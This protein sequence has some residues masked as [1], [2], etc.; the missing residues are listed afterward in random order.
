MSDVT[1]VSPDGDFAG[2][3]GELLQTS[4]RQVWQP[5]LAGSTDP[6][7]E[8]LRAD[9]DV[10]V[11]GPGFDNADDQLA[12][13]AGLEA[14]RPDL[15]VIVV[16]STEGS[17]ALAAMRAGAR[18][19]VDVDA[20]DD[21]L[22]EV[23]ER[24]RTVADRRRLSVSELDE[25]PRRRVITV[26]SPKGGTGKTTVSTNLAVGLARAGVGPVLL[27]DF[28]VQFGDCSGALGLEPEHHLDDAVR[29]TPLDRTVLKMFLAR[30][31]SG[32]HVLAPPASLA[33]ADDID[34][35]QLKVVMGLL[36]EEFPWVVIDTSA[37]I[38]EAA[39]VAME[40]STDLL[41]VGSTDVP[42][43]RALRRQVEALDRIAMNGP[44]RHLV[45]NRADARVGL[46]ADDISATVGLTVRHRIPSSRSI[47][48]STNQGTPAIDANARDSVGK[49]FNQLVA[50]FLPT[51]NT[52][53]DKRRWRKRP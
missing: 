14:R 11:V 43:V 31:E 41:F 32:L 29:A 2:R 40:F 50:S 52:A 38:D 36:V 27:V 35:D 5:D 44:E 49:A 51:T 18:D 22:V 10:V 47:P 34:G 20:D 19:V 30:H 3:I 4:V 26:L 12:V 28:D 37:G 6:V 24:A 46:E 1:I 25:S 16:G 9:P 33:I 42:A 21:E 8:A 53:S 23:V 7:S 13:V 15:A 39:L 48:I 45:L 17:F